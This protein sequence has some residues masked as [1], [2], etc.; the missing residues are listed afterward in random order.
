M[1]H[2][3]IKRYIISLLSAVVLLSS[4]SNG[5]EPLPDEVRNEKTLLMYLP[6]SSNL[7]TYFYQN[8]SDM[9]ACIAEMGGLTDERV[10]VFMSESATEASLFEIKYEQGR[11]VRT[12]VKTYTN[13]AFTT[14]EGIAGILDDV[15]VYA[16]AKRYSMI[17]GCHGMGWLP[18]NAGSSA[19]GEEMNHWD[20]SGT[21]LTR[22]FGGTTSEYQTD[23]S[24]LSGA[25]EECGVRMEYILFDDCY[26]SSIE[27]AYELKDV[28][29]YLIASTCEVMAYGMPYSTMGRHLLGIP[30]YG[31]VCEDFYKFYSN[32]TAMPCGTLSVTDLSHIEDMAAVMKRINEWCDF[33]EDQLGKI[34][35]LDGYSPT[36]FYDFGDYVKVLTEQDDAPEELVMEF[37]TKLQQLIPF[38]TNTERFFT[39]SRGPLKLDRYSGITTSDPSISH[40]A[41]DKTNTKWYAATH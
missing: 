17:I 33:D 18:V 14:K 35:N 19:R 21:L 2:M 1:K 24:T 26:M 4:C 7:T 12:D 5:D 11:C 31:A 30:D 36:I 38:K 6:W 20:Y 3:D 8:I 23:I 9:E 10:M 37:E 29:D 39:A 27:V 32:Y 41:A 16:P 25:I 28:A 40:R 15:M 22:Y 13:P 34:Q